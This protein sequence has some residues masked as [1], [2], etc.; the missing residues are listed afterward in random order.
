MRFERKWMPIVS[1]AL[2]LPSTILVSA[3]GLWQLVEEKIISENT[4]MFLFLALIAQMIFMM[5]YYANKRKS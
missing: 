1:L 2:G 5:V 4:A 3:V